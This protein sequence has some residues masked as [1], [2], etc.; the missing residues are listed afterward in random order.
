MGHNKFNFPITCLLV[1]GAE[2]MK[3]TLFY[4]R[5]FKNDVLTTVCSKT[6]HQW[7]QEKSL[8]KTAPPCLN[9][10]NRFPWMSVKAVAIQQYAAVLKT[11]RPFKF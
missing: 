8:H 4:L 3:Q 11:N 5:V 9:D 2:V 1:E 6:W 10:G 7:R